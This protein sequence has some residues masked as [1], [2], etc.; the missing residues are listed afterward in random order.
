MPALRTLDVKGFGAGR[1]GW[2]RY[3]GRDVERSRSEVVERCHG[4]QICLREFGHGWR[5]RRAPHWVQG[6]YT[7]SRECL[8]LHPSPWWNRC[9]DRQ[10]VGLDTSRVS[11]KHTRKPSLHS[12]R[13]RRHAVLGVCITSC[14]YCL[15]LRNFRRVGLGAHVWTSSSVDSSTR[16][17]SRVNR[18]PLANSGAQRRQPPVAPLQSILRL[19]D[20]RRTL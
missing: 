14:S 2:E 16:K 10:V 1:G 18:S 17:A 8:R 9:A 3:E 15:H 19:T 5:T 12:S 4:D 7:D 6:D 11:S 13:R 20:L